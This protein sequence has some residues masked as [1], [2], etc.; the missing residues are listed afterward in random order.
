MP[1]GDYILG[2]GDN[3]LSHFCNDREEADRIINKVKSCWQISGC[4]PLLRIC[5][6]RSWKCILGE[7]GFIHVK[8][9][10]FSFFS[11]DLIFQTCSKMNFRL[12]Y[13]S[14]RCE[15]IPSHY[16][17]NSYY[18]EYLTLLVSELQSIL[19]WCIEIFVNKITEIYT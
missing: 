6:I 15:C 19:C 16:T 8:H 9:K 13:C 17:T 10:T 12:H 14:G 7:I 2:S 4:C 11:H 5:L 3:H 18:C 1:S